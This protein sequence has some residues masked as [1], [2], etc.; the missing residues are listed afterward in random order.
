LPPIAATLK[1]E[2]KRERARRPSRSGSFCIQAIIGQNSV[3]STALPDTSDRLVA[4]SHPRCP[5]RPRD[6][7]GWLHLRVYV[8]GDLDLLLSREA[9]TY[10]SRPGM[11][12]LT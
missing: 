8:S 5:Q 1:K 3:H 12:S 11:E 7:R 10:K 2:L 4:S 9:P 6:S